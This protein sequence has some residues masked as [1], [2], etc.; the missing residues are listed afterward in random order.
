M[1]FYVNF[2]IFIC[3]LV[4]LYVYVYYKGLKFFYY[5]RNKLLSVEECI[6]CF[7]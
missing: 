1:I 3:E 6:S 4:R 7:I 2:E 5:I